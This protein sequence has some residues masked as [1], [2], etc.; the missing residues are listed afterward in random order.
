MKVKIRVENH[1]RGLTAVPMQDSAPAGCSGFLR[2][3]TAFEVG[4]TASKYGKISHDACKEK[5]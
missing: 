2:E 5:C 1:L 3:E 4:L